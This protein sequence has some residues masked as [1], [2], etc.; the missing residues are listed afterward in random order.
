MSKYDKLI[1]V[2]ELQTLI[3]SGNCRVIDCRFDLM[4]PDKGREEY[5]AG[6]IP[7]AVFADLDRDLAA[8]VTETTGRHPLPDHHEK[9]EARHQSDRAEPDSHHHPAGRH[10]SRRVVHPWSTYQSGDQVQGI[11]ADRGDTDV[12]WTGEGEVRMEGYDTP[13]HFTRI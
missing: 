13:H 1:E 12:V 6:H 2:A 7:G 11:K 9:G 4:Q 10:T 8:P 3:G 5:L